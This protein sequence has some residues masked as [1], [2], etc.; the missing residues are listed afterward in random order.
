MT[1]LNMEVELLMDFLRSGDRA[2]YGGGSK[3]SYFGGDGL[4]FILDL[5]VG[6]IDYGNYRVTEGFYLVGQTESY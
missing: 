6:V 3:V 4:D 5:K 1:R 2:D